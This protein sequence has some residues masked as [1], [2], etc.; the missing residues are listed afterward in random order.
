MR[1]W[2]VDPMI[3][4]R[5]HLLGEHV[6]NHMFVG[7]LKK[8]MKLDG[9]FITNCFEPSSLQS[10]HKALAGEMLRRTYKHKSPWIASV[11]LIE[12]LGDK[13][14]IKVNIDAA[15][16]DLLNRCPICLKRYNFINELRKSREVQNVQYR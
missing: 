5:K 11:D 16:A 10:R 2:M 8:K 7:S 14:I 6:E 9:Y 12:Y 4:C 3:L 13:Q 1:M 15:L